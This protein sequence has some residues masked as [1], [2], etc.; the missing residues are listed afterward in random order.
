MLARIH[1]NKIIEMTDEQKNYLELKNLILKDQKFLQS[2]MSTIQQGFK[3]FIKRQ[4]KN[5]L[6]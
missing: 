2:H 5:I 1:K 3:Q 6:N 4:I